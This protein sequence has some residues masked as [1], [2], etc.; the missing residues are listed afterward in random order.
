[1]AVVISRPGGYGGTTVPLAIDQSA[2]PAPTGLQGVSSTGQIV[3]SF[4]QTADI[5]DSVTAASGIASY[6]LELDGV[7]Q[8]ITAPSANILGQPTLANIGAITPPPTLVQSGTNWT[9]TA[10]GN[11]I[12]GTADQ[13]GF[14]Y[15]SVTGDCAL[16]D[17]VTSFTGSGQDFA[18]AGQMLRNSTAV[19]SV[20]A[21]NYQWLLG[22]NQGV[23][24]KHRLTLDG[25]ISGVNYAVGDN[26]TRYYRKTVCIGTNLTY[27][28]STD[29]N[30]WQTLASDAV[31]NLNSSKLVGFF[32]SD[33][34][35]S[36]TP[37][38]LTAQFDGPR[39]VPPAAV[40]YVQSSA[41]TTPVIARVRAR[42]AAGNVSTWSNSL[43]VTPGQVTNATG[44]KWHP[45]NYIVA[46]ASNHPGVYANNQWQPRSEILD[47]LTS[48]GSSTNIKGVLVPGFW[49]YWEGNTAGD[50]SGGFAIVD[51]LLEKCAS[52]TVPKRL[53]IKMIPEAYEYPLPADPGYDNAPDYLYNAGI[54]LHNQ[55]ETGLWIAQIDK[56]PGM[57]RLIALS[58]AY[59]ARYDSHPLFE[60]FC[61]MEQTSMPFA[62]FDWTTYKT[63]MGRL[64]DSMQTAW[65]H[66]LVRCPINFAGNNDTQCRELYDLVRRPGV[67]F[68]GPDCYPDSGRPLQGDRVYR[69]LNSDGT[70][71]SGWA[72]YRGQYGWVSEVEG[73]VDFAT[74]S[75]STKEQIRD[76]GKNTTRNNYFVWWPTSGNNG[77]P[78]FAALISWIDGGNAAP[79]ST[80]CPSSFPA[81]YTGG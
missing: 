10:A 6:D 58:N 36:H 1:M 77:T 72:D 3:W 2:P 51:A 24:A 28:Y 18:Y 17:R 21:A 53:I 67:V 30:N 75:T 69:G 70:T 26:I 27:Y 54:V 29:G 5:H 32:T 56:Q 34:N 50:Y 68:G 20:Y 81:C 74:Y 22:G 38:V 15:W 71:H 65:A 33:L 73:D 23:E 48:I 45:G 40:S 12:D 52:L 9:L 44:Y 16:I 39:V 41:K 46:V 25:S 13:V 66:T 55:G 78:T 49:D 61:P 7:I 62:N 63:Q 37:V 47:F 14:A 19:G 59:A 64:H 35:V 60:M 76:Y 79:Y 43:A 4:D 80:A 42:D 31:A 11:G 57:D 8:T